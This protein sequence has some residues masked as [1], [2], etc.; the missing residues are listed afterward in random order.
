MIVDTP[1]LGWV[2]AIVA[3][4]LLG[5]AKAGIKGIGVVIVTFLAL[6]FGSRASTGVLMPLLLVGDTFAVIYYRSHVQWRVL[7]RLLPW[8]IAGVLAGVWFGKDL[9]EESFKLW[10]AILILGATTL[11]IAGELHRSLAIPQNK[12]FGWIMGL[13]AG[14]S[15][16]I[17]NLAGPFA[18]LFFL[19][20]RLTKNHFIGTAAWLFFLVNIFKLPFHIFV[21]HTITFRS[22]QYD[23]MLLP[24][25]VIGLWAGV[26]LVS[27]IHEA[28]YR[29]IVIVLTAAG[30]ILILF[31]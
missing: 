29:R 15:T 26:K 22:L 31:G 1:V 6:A 12:V 9:H 17:G 19:A 20:M 4:F 3:V 24:A 25:I 8:V 11:M 18:N 21:W 23:L 16:M 14:F 2:L 13:L 27:R 10:M 30:A 5:L 7:W 28:R